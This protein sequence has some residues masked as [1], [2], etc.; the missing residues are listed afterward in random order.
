MM[1]VNF[2]QCTFHAS[3]DHDSIKY[4]LFSIQS[5]QIYKESCRNDS[6]GETYLVEAMSD[7]DKNEMNIL[8]MGKNFLI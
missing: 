6:I 8:D 7:N 5:E 2:I 1:I 3:I 4:F